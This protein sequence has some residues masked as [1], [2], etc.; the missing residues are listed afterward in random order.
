[1]A[2]TLPIIIDNGGMERFFPLFGSVSPRE[3]IDGQAGKGPHAEFP[4]IG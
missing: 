3:S 4:V 1:M 2:E